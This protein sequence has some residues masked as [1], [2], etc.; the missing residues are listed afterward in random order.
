MREGTESPLVSII[1]VTLNDESGICK[2]VRSLQAWS[3]EGA[4]E[5]IVVDGGS[6][7]AIDAVLGALNWN[8][9]LLKGK[10][11]GLYDAMNKGLM[12]ARGKYLWFLNSG[13][14][15]P[16]GDTVRVVCG[17]LKA[18]TPDI[19]YGDSWEGSE[20]DGW[21]YKRAK[22]L[23]AMRTGMITHH[24]A[25][26]FRRGLILDGNIKYDLAF[27]IAADYDF[28]LRSLAA[29]ERTQYL[30]LPIC[31]FEPDGVSQRYPLRG[32]RDQFA[33]RRKNGESYL[34]AAALFGGQTLAWLWRRMW[35]TGYWLLKRRLW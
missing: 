20:K 22:P 31:G 23:W 34:V 3:G 17:Q 8:G 32:R 26:I 19:L 12:K 11:R 9:T 24:Q 28:V 7:Y 4:V 30:P 6:S 2:T 1:T 15:I 18:N 21:R 35:P 10:D 14:T 29:S 5:H 16:S 33:V 13:D 25:I 27:P